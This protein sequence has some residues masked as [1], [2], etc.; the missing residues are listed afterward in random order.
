MA[1]SGY[2]RIT[3]FFP[4]SP[5]W[6]CRDEIGPNRNNTNS[7]WIFCNRRVKEVG[8]ELA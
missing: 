5:P 4:W 8:A 7:S 1:G 3:A 2:Y 6:R